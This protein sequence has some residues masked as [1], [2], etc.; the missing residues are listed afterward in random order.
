MKP[1]T[2]D[3]LIKF[4]NR[5]GIYELPEFLSQIVRNGWASDFAEAE[6][7]MD[8]LGVI[9]LGRL[10]LSKRLDRIGGLGGNKEMYKMRLQ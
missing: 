5:K 7:Y 4:M 10:I 1:K 6:I 9:P 8:T 2:A 3:G